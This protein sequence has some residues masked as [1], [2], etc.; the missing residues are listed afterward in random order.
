ML[1]IIANVE[2][3]RQMIVEGWLTGARFVGTQM[4]DIAFFF[5]Q[6]KVRAKFKTT[7]KVC[8]F[9]EHLHLS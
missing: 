6:N 2:M 1:D 8:A 3:P 7:P 9:N 5:R 4:K